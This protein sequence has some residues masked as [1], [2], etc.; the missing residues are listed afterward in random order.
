MTFSSFILSFASTS[1]FIIWF[2]QLFIAFLLSFTGDICA[3]IDF[4][5]LVS[6]GEF[7]SFVSYLD[8]DTIPT[9]IIYRSVFTWNNRIIICVAARTH[10]SNKHTYESRLIFPFGKERR[11]ESSSR[12]KKKRKKKTIFT[13]R[14]PLRSDSFAR[15]RAPSLFHWIEIG[16]VM[17]TVCFRRRDIVNDGRNEAN[18]REMLNININENEKIKIE[19]KSNEHNSLA[20]KQTLTHT[21]QH[22]D[23]TA[24][25]FA[26]TK[27][28]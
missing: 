12:R 21:S 28:R 25:C 17:K 1:F 18:A 19:M 13:S 9:I 2:V 4:V 14:S 11:I 6:L 10:C 8:E 3:S 24:Y 22:I 15:M 5:P 16:G 27:Y 23:Y 7:V 26:C 20:P